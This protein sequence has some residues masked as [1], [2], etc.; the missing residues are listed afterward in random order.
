MACG[1][2]G[3]LY[4]S[5]GLTDLIKEDDNCFLIQPDP[6]LIAAKIIALKNHP[7]MITEKGN[8]ALQFVTKNFNMAD[9]VTLISALY[10]N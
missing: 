1:L 2:P 7:A 5:P 10:R 6:A 3:I 4:N 8:N 9:S